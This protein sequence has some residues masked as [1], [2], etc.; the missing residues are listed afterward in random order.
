[1]RMGTKIPARLHI[2][3]VAV[4]AALLSAAI[5]APSA[6]TLPCQ[7][8]I[9]A[10]VVALDQV[11]T[12]NRFGAFNPLGM[13]YALKRDVVPIDPTL[14]MGPGNARLRDTKRPRPLV[15]RANVG[16]CLQVTFRNWLRPQAPSFCDPSDPVCVP[17]N[18]PFTRTAS[19]HVNGLQYDVQRADGSRV[20]FNSSSLIAPGQSHVSTWYADRQGT[21]LVHSHGALSGGEGDGG[22]LVLGLFGAVNVEPA[23]SRWLRSQLT[24]RELNLVRRRVCT[25]VC[26]DGSTTTT[27]SGPIVIDDGGG[28]GGGG[29]TTTCKWVFDYDVTDPLR[30]NEPVAR[31]LNPSNAIVHSDVDAIIDNVSE[32]CSVGPPSGTCGRFREFSV[33]FHDELKAVQAFPELKNDPTFHGVRDGFG[34]NYGASGMG[35]ILLANFEGVGPAANCAE[36]KFEE[37]F[38]SSWPNGDPALLPEFTDDPSNVHHSYLG[39]P[40]KFR[41]VHAGPKETHVFHLH[42]HQWLHEENGEDSTYLDSQTIGPGS[43]FTYEINYGGAGNRN[44]TPGDAI[45][46]CHL[47]PHFAQGMWELWR[48][49]DVFEDGSPLRKL[50]DG[51]IPG[52]TPIPGLLPMP[53]LAMAPDPTPGFPGYP[54][55][56]GAAA[57]PDGRGALP[58]RRAPQAPLDLEF[59]G[60]LP[61]HVVVQAQ[62]H[63]GRRGQFDK[64]FKLPDGTPLPAQLSLLPPGGTPSE[65]RAMSFHAQ[66]THQTQFPDGTTAGALFRT[67]GLPPTPGAPFAEPCDPNGTTFNRNYRAAAL[68][69]DLLVNDDGWHDPQARINLLNDDVPGVI[70]DPNPQ[71]AQP[72]FVRANSGECVTFH[73]TNLTPATLEP[74][75]FQI[76]TPTDTIGQHIHLVKFDVTASDGAANGFN[77]EDGSFAGEEVE[78]RIN[79]HNAWCTDPNHPCPTLT[80][81]QNPSFPGLAEGR[82]AQTTV[83]RWWADPLVN[84]SGLDRT[85]RTVFTHD[86]FSPSSI[87]HHGFYGAVVV[88]PAGSRWFDPETGAELG[89]RPTDGGPTLWKANIETGD[90]DGDLKDDS[91]RE[92]NLAFADFAIVFDGLGNPVNAPEVPEAISAADPGTMLINYANEP[93]PLRISKQGAGLQQAGG[94]KGDMAFAFSSR[95]HGDPFTPL[96]ETYEKDRV[97]I[98]LV[99]GAQEEQHVFSMHGVRWPHEPSDPKSGWYAAQAIGISE[100]FEFVTPIPQACPASRRLEPWD[101]DEMA[102][103]TF[104]LL[105]PDPTTAVGDPSA[106]EVKAALDARLQ[107]ELSAAAGFND[108]S[109]TQAGD[110]SVDRV[111]GDADKLAVLGSGGSTQGFYVADASF[112]AGGG[113]AAES[114][115]RVDDG[116]GTFSGGFATSITRSRRERCFGDYLYG[117]PSLDDSWNGMWGLLR[118]HRELRSDLV[119]LPNNAPPGTSTAE[120]PFGVSGHPSLSPHPQEPHPCQG[121]DLNGN[122]KVVT[123]NRTY[124]VVAIAKSITYNQGDLIKDPTGLLFVPAADEQAVLGGS[125]PPQ[126]LVL[127]AAGGECLT[128]NLTNH[129]PPQVPDLTGDAPLPPIVGLNVDGLKPSRRVSLHPQLVD[130]NIRRGDGTAVGFNPDQTVRRNK[131]VAYQWYVPFDLRGPRDPGSILAA[132]PESLGGTNLRD[133]GDIIKHGSQGLFGGLML[134]PNG[135]TF[136]T[137][138]GDTAVV[139]TSSGPFR[140]FVVFYQDGLNLRDRNGNAL[141]DFPG[142]PAPD[143][144]DPEDSGEK[145]FNFKTEPFWTRLCHVLVNGVCD[146]SVFDLNEEEQSDVLSSF[147]HGD[148]ETPLFKAT[149]GEAVRFRLLEPDGRARQHAWALH[150]HEWQH[151]PSNPFSMTLGAQGGMSVGRHFNVHPLYGAG[152]LTGTPGDYLYRD[153]PSFQFSGGLWGIL[154]VEAPPPPPPGGGGGGKKIIVE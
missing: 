13:I 93:I 23:G 100:H 20:G 124:D 25:T 68:Q 26:P 63:K 8:T 35:A 104:D 128:V 48:V 109:L 17:E 36:C 136:S 98:R 148:P 115:Y 97:K 132:G 107:R 21:Y 54:F 52:G 122:P 77:Y 5:D 78:E 105:D 1:M 96:L 102:F 43:A 138:H 86:H 22:S 7:R 39:D 106:V 29:C 123:G 80:V 144:V 79:A 30:E 64:E 38:L 85:I 9:T 125:K 58:G 60:G 42:A 45:F 3:M 81:Q 76:F 19:M 51:E 6:Q 84:R 47:Y 145:G 59:D 83:Q 62:V 24:N 153:M 120:A 34:I 119:P 110:G 137:P 131:T 118:A 94:P 40:V 113:G 49:H 126:P 129:L 69:L 41:N 99:Q 116:S 149:A 150:G 135:A 53:G 10:E 31:I 46:H 101:L 133:F 12:F 127:R 114:T 87:Q 44:L 4:P 151:E 88:E 14:P 92:F 66:R 91:Y 117:S 143:E 65:V 152:G 18:G 67:N 37:F 73:H 130:V 111:L 71:P 141:P 33:I 134:E 147:A 61:R 75:P 146:F 56:L 103:D 140:E 154:R 142:H 16:D 32:N 121:V 82:G 95:V 2:T 89:T 72:F 70:G 112:G 15:L 11:F 28:G 50:P 55:Y 90:L 27:E 74:D 139:T 57:N 108:L